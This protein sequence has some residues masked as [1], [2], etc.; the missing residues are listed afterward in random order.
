MF[1]STAMLPAATKHLVR[2]APRHPASDSRVR[3][4]LH[5]R[6]PLLVL[7][8]RKLPHLIFRLRTGENR[9]KYAFRCFFPV[10]QRTR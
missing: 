7:R 9:A 10:S 8:M 4:K 2:T 1:C 6:S 3:N 5:T